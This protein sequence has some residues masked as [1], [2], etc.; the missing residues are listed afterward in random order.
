MRNVNKKDFAVICSIKNDPTMDIYE[1]ITLLGLI[2]AVEHGTPRQ[3]TG[4]GYVAA[5]DCVGIGGIDVMTGNG[6]GMHVNMF[7]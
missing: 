2:Y 7:S 1:R 4:G 6:V 3:V 5:E